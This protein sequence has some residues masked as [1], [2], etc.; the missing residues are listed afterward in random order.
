MLYL[1]YYSIS[2]IIVLSYLIAF[3]FNPVCFYVYL[4][5]LYLS[6]NDE[7]ILLYKN[8]VLLVSNN[9]ALSGSQ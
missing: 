6:S 9:S 3:F 1:T 2:N 8:N 5:V 7:I 4:H